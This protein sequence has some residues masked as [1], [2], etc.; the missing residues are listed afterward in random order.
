[1]DAPCKD[2]PNAGCG[3]YHD[4]CEKYLVYRE[5]QKEEYAKRKIASQLEADLT[6]V[7]CKRIW[8]NKKIRHKG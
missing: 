5:A 1:M 4:I 7:E 3:S 6:S 2:C 8:R